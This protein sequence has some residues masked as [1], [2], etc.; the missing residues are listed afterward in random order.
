MMDT[1]YL[2]AGYKP[3]NRRIFDEVISKY[4]TWQGFAKAVER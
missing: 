3:W 4:P 2:V 1:T